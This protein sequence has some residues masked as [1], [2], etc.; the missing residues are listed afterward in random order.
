MNIASTIVRLFSSCFRSTLEPFAFHGACS[1]LYFVFCSSGF[2]HIFIA[3]WP[4]I[5]KG[6]KGMMEVSV[7]NE[8]AI[9]LTSVCYSYGNLQLLLE[10][11]NFYKIKSSSC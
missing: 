6:C 5:H 7:E 9:R 8:V 3:T 4:V 1:C 10:N 2:S 11:L